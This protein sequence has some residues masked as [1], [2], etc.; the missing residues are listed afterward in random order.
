MKL[1]YIRRPIEAERAR[2]AELEALL[3]ENENQKKIIQEAQERREMD[4]LN[5]KTQT[6]RDVEAGVAAALRCHERQEARK[7]RARQQLI[8]L[9][10]VMISILIIIFTAYS[11][12]FVGEDLS[13]F[14]ARLTMVAASWKAGNLWDA[15]WKEGEV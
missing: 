15:A 8:I 9:A 1:T 12:G 2:R 5:R 11:C 7:I 14:A 3:R 4:N 6:R 10:A 13:R